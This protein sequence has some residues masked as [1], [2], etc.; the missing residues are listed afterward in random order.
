M[1]W[2]FVIYKYVDLDTQEFTEVLSNSDGDE[3]TRDSYDIMP[4][5]DSSE[6][7]DLIGNTAD[8][9]RVRGDGKET[10]QGNPFKCNVIHLQ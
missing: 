7:G 2:Y 10:E 8:A 9:E 6:Q 1:W 5:P 3:D 4:L